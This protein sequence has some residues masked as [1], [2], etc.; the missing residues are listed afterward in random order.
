MH[1]SRFAFFS[2]TIA[3][4]DLDRDGA[5]YVRIFHM[6]DRHFSSNEE[7]VL[8]KKG[9]D[10][11]AE[12]GWCTIDEHTW[13]YEDGGVRFFLLTGSERALL[14]DSGMTVH[15]ARELAGELTALPI[16][17]FNTHCDRDHVGSNDE[18]DEVWISPMELVHPQAP[19]NSQKVRPV[20]DGEVIELGGRELEAIALPGHT[21][22]SMALLDR[23]SGMLFSGDPIQRDGRIFMFG[24]MRSL[25]A[26]IHSLQR[27]Q[28]R[29]GEVQSIWPCHATCPIGP[30]T[31]GELIAGAEAVERGEATYQM[32]EFHGT[33]VRAYEAG[34]LILLCDAE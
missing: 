8:L 3:Y 24:P 6:L 30:E 14:V 13:R 32:E 1:M 27:L 5:N 33:A 34:P 10:S 31:V 15:N 7:L 12:S 21:P 2:G 26:Y 11:M 23:S 22:G 9:E 17:L 4:G 29:I 25:A 28:G 16:A 20:W 18:F 19:H